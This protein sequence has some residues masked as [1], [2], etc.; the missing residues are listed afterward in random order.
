MDGREDS[1]TSCTM[2]GSCSDV[3]PSRH[4]MWHGEPSCESALTT[5]VELRTP[6][7]TD[8]RP[9]SEGLDSA[10]IT[11]HSHRSPPTRKWEWA[12]S[13]QSQDPDRSGVWEA[14]LKVFIQ[15]GQ[16]AAPCPPA[17]PPMGM[18]QPRGSSQRPQA[19]CRVHWRLGAQAQ[20]RAACPPSMW[21]KQPPTAPCW[22]AH[23]ACSVRKA[24]TRSVTSRCTRCR[25]T[26]LSAASIVKRCCVQDTNK[27]ASSTSVH[28]MEKSVKKNQGNISQGV[29]K[30]Q[31][32][33][34]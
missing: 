28:T 9:S 30:D 31:F 3:A 14:Q 15:R 21:P 32:S 2:F 5:F 25:G 4:S 24:A 13:R 19:A 29:A 11:T 1:K 23:L 34:P 16:P 22:L 20:W 8:S 33:S 17:H 26:F 12:N 6:S 7:I 10:A 27:G 18:G